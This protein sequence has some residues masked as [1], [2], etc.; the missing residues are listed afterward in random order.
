M[1]HKSMYQ[2]IEFIFWSKTVVYCDFD[3]FTVKCSSLV[4]QYY[5]EYNDSPIIRLS[6]DTAKSISRSM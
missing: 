3:F 2:T 6:H 1:T 4:K 5:T